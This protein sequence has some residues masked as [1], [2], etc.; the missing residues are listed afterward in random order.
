MSKKKRPKE[1]VLNER[2]FRFINC[3]VRIS[4]WDEFVSAH[5]GEIPSE[6][7]SD[8]IVREVEQMKKKKGA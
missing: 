5:F 4:I 2:G 8:L 6:A 1:A 7:L 3:V